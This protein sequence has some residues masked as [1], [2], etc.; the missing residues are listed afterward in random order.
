MTVKSKVWE[1]EK[2]AALNAAA[3]QRFSRAAAAEQAWQRA[4]HEERAAAARAVAQAEAAAAGKSGTRAGTRSAPGVLRTRVQYLQDN[5]I[6]SLL[7][8]TYS[9]I[10]V[11][12]YIGREKKVSDTSP[13]SFTL[14][15]YSSP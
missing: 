4:I 2:Q 15:D 9:S 3:A 5:G 12:P 1:E 14:I 10:T 6:L 13:G 11:K 8:T 7:C